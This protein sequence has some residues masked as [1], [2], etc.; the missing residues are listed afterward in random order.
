[1]RKH[2][3]A[4][5]IIIVMLCLGYGLWLYSESLRTNVDLG[6]LLKKDLAAKRESL[7]GFI[8]GDKAK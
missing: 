6:S 3:T 4:V 8:F 7:N 5:L 1:M 2:T